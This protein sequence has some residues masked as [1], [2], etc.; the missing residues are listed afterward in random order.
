MV[1][2]VGT[3]DRLLALYTKFSW[4]DGVVRQPLAE[5]I[6]SA[7]MSIFCCLPS[8]HLAT[9]YHRRERAYMRSSIPHR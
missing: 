3:N 4:V 2:G 7:M 6:I 8:P 5:P 9:S 1:M